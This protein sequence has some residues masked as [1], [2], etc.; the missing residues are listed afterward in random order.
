MILLHRKTKRG[1]SQYF[2]EIRGNSVFGTTAIQNART[3]RTYEQAESVKTV[4][5]NV[6]KYDVET[7]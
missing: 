4:I 1:H 5:A 2:L 6:V 3:F 7:V